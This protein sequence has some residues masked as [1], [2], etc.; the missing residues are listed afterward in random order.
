M[1][2]FD[3]YEAGL[4]ICSST[5]EKPVIEE[6]PKHAKREREYQRG[7][8]HYWNSALSPVFTVCLVA[9]YSSAVGGSLGSTS[10]MELARAW[11]PQR[12]LR[13]H[14]YRPRSETAADLWRSD[15]AHL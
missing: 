6:E 12:D 14:T 13:V 9:G 15:V 3:Y 2:S 1:G 5:P 8:F 11:P 10:R 7:K 4:K